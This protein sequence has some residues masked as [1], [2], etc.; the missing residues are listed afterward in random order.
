MSKVNPLICDFSAGE[1]S[2]KMDARADSEIY[3]KGCKKLENF[4]VY[5]HGGVQ[6]R[7]GTRYVATVKYPDKDTRIL[8]Y[9]YGESIAYVLEFGDHYMR[10][11]TNGGQV[12]VGGAPY[13][14]VTPYAYSDVW[15]IK[16][17]Q[18]A[19]VMYMVHPDYAPQKLI[20][21][22][23]D[24]WTM[25]AVGFVNGPFMDENI[26]SSYV[27]TATA[28]TGNI[29]VTA[30]GF[31]PFSAGHV[32]SIWRMKGNIRN[33]AEINI[34]DSWTDSVEADRNESIFI[35]L[36]GVWE[37]TVTLQ[38][39]ANDGATWEDVYV[40]KDNINTT[41]TEYEDDII[42]RLG[43]KS[44]DYTSGTASLTL[45]K[46][47]QYGYF[48]ITNYTS[49]TQ[50]TGTVQKV[51]PTVSTSK[52]TEGAWSGVNGYPRAVAFF[53][54]KL[55]FAGTYAEPQT[56]W[57]SQ[58]D[59]YEN[60]ETGVTLADALVITLASNNINTI[61]WL[62]DSQSTL[63]IGTIGSEWHLETTDTPPFVNAYKQSSFGSN[64][65]QSIP[66]G[67]LILYIQKGGKK[68]RQRYY[69]YEPDTWISNEISLISE[70]MFKAG[71]YDL[72]Y[73][74]DPEPM[75]LMTRADGVIVGCTFDTVNKVIAY[76]TLTT[77]GAYQSVTSIPVQLGMRCGL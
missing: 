3:A 32:G 20:R 45:G 64:F 13:E 36:G 51:L 10:V 56:L 28:V 37:G 49:T 44:G 19:D 54:E 38:R 16:F 25:A 50:V 4:Y 48:K 31:A 5:V 2:P 42:Y 33:S 40:Y 1:L 60:F 7:P 61:Q 23:D 22:A 55:I 71:I 11:Y 34:D 14:I 9:I 72:T 17:V 57:F 66:V 67:Q 58:T 70:H 6:K 65:I 29:T 73:I 75:V 69:S 53:E 47:N 43:I 21:Y 41:H 27:L 18:S 12:Q 68:L 30:T 24:S 15:D 63:H 62:L 59:D 77:D 8:S 35:E 52:W 39:S 76:F 74:D 46:L 26:Q